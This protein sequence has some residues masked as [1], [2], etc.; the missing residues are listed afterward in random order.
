MRGFQPVTDEFPAQMASNADIVSIWWRHHALD[1]C[2]FESTRCKH[3][4]IY[5][6]LLLYTRTYTRAAMLASNSVRAYAPIFPVS[7][8]KWFKNTLSVIVYTV[9]DGWTDGRRDRQHHT[10][11]RP[12]KTGVLVLLTRS[13]RVTHT[14]VSKFTIIGSVNG[15]SPGRRQAIIWTNAGILLIRT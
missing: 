3:R 12:V 7:K 4:S 11:I 14:C 9:N 6:I 15:F 1:A 5:Y 8:I 2:P 10:M 13:A